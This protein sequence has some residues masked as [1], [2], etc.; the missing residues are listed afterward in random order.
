[1]QETFDLWLA[2]PFNYYY[3]V[4]PC[5]CISCVWHFDTPIYSDETKKI[6]EEISNTFM[7]VA[8]I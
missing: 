7:I 1:M 4:R 6:I 8:Q 5:F 2:A 3:I